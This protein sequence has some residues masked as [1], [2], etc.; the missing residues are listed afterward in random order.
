MRDKP[1]SK[2]GGDVGRHIRASAGY[3][4]KM[5]ILWNKPQLNN[6]SKVSTISV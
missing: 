2:K 6:A 3:V 5:R 1:L 4:D